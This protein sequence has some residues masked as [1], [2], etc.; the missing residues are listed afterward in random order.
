MYS[1]KNR[2]ILGR[3]FVR[4]ICKDSTLRAS[5]FCKGLSQ[6]M[7]AMHTFDPDTKIKD[8]QW[9]RHGDRCP[10]KMLWAQTRK[11][12]ML[13]TF[14]DCNGL[15]HM[16]FMRRGGSIT[17]EEY[18]AVL[19][20]LREKIR[21]KRPHLWAMNGD[22]RTFLLHHDNATPHTCIDTLATLGENHMEMV[23]HPT[24]PP[25]AQT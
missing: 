23:A 19:G 14:F 22:W 5:S 11:S 15:I 9:I 7:R 21:C 3:N 16:E 8:T 17:E 12:I 13:T 20:Q 6:G 25:I 4:R 1:L 2:R 18:C 10:S 24:H